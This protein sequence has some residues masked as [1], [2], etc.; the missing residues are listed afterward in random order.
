MGVLNVT[1][2]SFSGDGILD[3]PEAV[4]ARAERLV[5]E[6]AD[7][8]DVGGESTRPGYVPVDA[9]EE[10]RRVFPVL[11]SLAGRC[12]APVSID[13]GKA[14][15]A[16]G[17][18]E[19]GATVVNDVSGLRDPD[20]ISV[21]AGT[22]CGLILVH[23]DPEL[24]GLDVVQGVQRGLERLV[25]RAIEGGVERS[26]LMVDPGLG[27]AKPWRQNLELLNRLAELRTLGLPI[28][29]GPSRKATISRVL[30]VASTDR[31]EGTE[32]LVA[33][34]IAHGADLIRVHDCRPMARVAR[35]VD[36]MVRGSTF[37]RVYERA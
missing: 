6:G 24:R 2:D 18:L 23:N 34:S 20:M 22:K 12:A 9:A 13:T 10:M 21:V 30:G 19:R 11:E 29:V 28:V 26:Q 35:M 16:Y 1:P 17:A 3:D 33:V 36:A 14:S 8:L 15:V 25:S 27:F 31:L 7:L 37:R 5:G 32:A 4:V